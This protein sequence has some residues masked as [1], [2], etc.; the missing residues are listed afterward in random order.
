MSESVNY[1]EIHAYMLKKTREYYQCP[2][3]D[4]VDAVMEKYRKD[5]KIISYDDAQKLVS[6]IQIQRFV[7]AEMQKKWPE[8]MASIP[9]NPLRS[10]NE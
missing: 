4:L 6:P 8:F 5:G 10:E 3:A 2:P 7:K 9:S 1:K